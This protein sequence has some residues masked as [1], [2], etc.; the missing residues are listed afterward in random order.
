MKC[1]ARVALGVAGGYFLGRTKKMKLALMLG[2]MAAGRR[3]GGPGELLSQGG[4][5]LSSNPEIAALTEQVRGR[6]MEAGKNAVL[7]VATRQVESLTD[8]VGK[9][10]E[11]LG[12]LGS[13]VK[14][15]GKD[16]DAKDSDTEDS[17]AKD[18]DTEEEPVDEPEPEASEDED[19]SASDEADEETGSDDEA[20]E[21]PAPRRRRSA[22]AG[23][24]AESTG[25][26]ATSRARSTAK[27]VGETA[28]RSANSRSRSKIAAKSSGSSSSGT[29]RRRTTRRSGDA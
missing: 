22:R 9:R 19:T 13:S 29:T 18:S 20:E 5:L 4:K 28:G 6:L 25:R 26:A 24:A 14:G 15:R 23:T 2:G 21:K 11:S 7:S 10:V 3:A 27:K 12:G 17:D 8:R 16:S 1:G